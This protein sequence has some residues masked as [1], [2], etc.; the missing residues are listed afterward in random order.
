MFRK[1]ISILLITLLLLPQSNILANESSDLAESSKSAF[2]IEVDTGTVLY[3]KDS[4]K[5]LP[6][7]SMTK[8]MTMLLVM[9]ELDSGSLT[10]DET[11]QISEHAASMGGTQIYLEPFEEMSVKDLLKA[12]A[13]GSA[14]DAS[15]ALAER[16]AVTEEAFVER[17]N[18]RAEELGLSDTNFVNA[19]GLPA[20]NQYSTAHDMAKIGQALLEHEKI[21]DY[22]KV[23]ED[24]LREGTDDE[25]WLVNTN[26]LVKFYQGVDGLKTGYTSEA[27]Y[28]LTATAKR[29]EMRLI[30]VVMGAETTKDRN[31]DITNMFDYG[32]G[33]YELHQL[34]KA[35]EVLFSWDH[36]KA[37]NDYLVAVPKTNISLLLEKGDKLDDYH[38]EL[39]MEDLEQWPLS[40]GDTIGKIEVYKGEELLHEYPLII[41]DEV[42]DASVWT[43]WKRMMNKLH[44][45][46]MM[47]NSN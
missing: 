39:A 31:A 10:L 43:L 41:R 5:R 47:S 12:V 36:M 30:A 17:M 45:R 26:K 29:G 40:Q 21:T 20:D 4:D 18:E 16:I 3:N 25:F 13:I 1:S 2:L 6:P 7:A 23:Y 46:E 34:H 27:K 19:T 35:G 33:Q 15:V 28:N 14:N 9:E 32:F 24:Y 37:D 8:L 11:V 38:T 22:T 42:E 44:H